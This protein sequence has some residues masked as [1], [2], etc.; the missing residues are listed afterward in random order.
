MRHFGRDR[1]K[2]RARTT[3][4]GRKNISCLGV[5]REF[6]RRTVGQGGFSSKREKKNGFSNLQA[7]LAEDSR[8]DGRKNS[9]RRRERGWVGN[10]RRKKAIKLIW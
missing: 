1:R 9:L 7:K 5:K 10:Q 8:D 3:T 6:V 2:A 4:T